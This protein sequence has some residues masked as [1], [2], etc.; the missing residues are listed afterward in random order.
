MILDI[1]ETEELAEARIDGAEHI[2]MGHILNEEL[3][4]D[5]DKNTEILVMCRSGRR[6]IP[7]VDKLHELGYTNAKVYEG[8]II[9]WEL[10]GN[11]VIRGGD[12]E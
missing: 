3:L 6:A 10:E 12:N 8:G 11:P 9:R 5:V 2:P 7:V 4:P 1:R